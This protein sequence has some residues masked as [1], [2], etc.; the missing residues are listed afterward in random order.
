MESAHNAKNKKT[1]K[2]IV[3]IVEDT[4]IHKLRNANIFYGAVLPR[5]LLAHFQLSC[6]GLHALDALAL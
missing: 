6:G 3:A 5:E 1:S 4:W 2:F